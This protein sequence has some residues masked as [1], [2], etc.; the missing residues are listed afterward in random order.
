MAAGHSLEFELSG[1]VSPDR[2]RISGVI[3]ITP[4]LY[5]LYLAAVKLR[6]VSCQ[7]P[8]SAFP[9]PPGCLVKRQVR[10]FLQGIIKMSPRSVHAAPGPAR[11]AKEPLIGFKK[12]TFCPLR[13]QLH[14]LAPR[15]IAKMRVRVH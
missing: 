12:N 13:D 2:K 9:D 10:G 1:Q 11:G 4:T 5:E 14:A 3:R 8:I 6:P 7:G 15:Q